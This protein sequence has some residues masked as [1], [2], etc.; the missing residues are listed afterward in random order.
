IKKEAFKVIE[1]LKKE[2]REYKKLFS[3]VSDYFG[4]AWNLFLDKNED[5]SIKDEEEIRNKEEDNNNESK[6]EE[7]KENN[8]NNNDI[9][10][11]ISLLTDEY[12]IFLNE[13]KCNNFIY[14]EQNHINY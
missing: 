4:H 12:N 14:Y 10:Y 2:K 11:Y 7:K 6:V 9:K 1:K 3:K 5:F 13:N 8:Y